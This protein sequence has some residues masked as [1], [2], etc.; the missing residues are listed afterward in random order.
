MAV[1]LE[2]HCHVEEVVGFGGHAKGPQREESIDRASRKRVHDRMKVLNIPPI[3]GREIDVLRDTGEFSDVPRYWHEE[4]RDLKDKLESGKVSQFVGHPPGPLEKSKTGPRKDGR[5]YT[6]EFRRYE[7]LRHI[8]KG[9]ND[10]LR[11][12]QDLVAQQAEI[13]ALDLR[14]HDP[15]LSDEEREA[16]L[17]EYDTRNEALKE[18]VSTLTYNKRNQFLFLTDDRHAFSMDPPLLSWDN[19]TYEPLT[20]SPSEFYNPRELALLDFQAKLPNTLPLTSEQ[21]IYMDLLGTALFARKGP[22]NLRVLKTVAPGAYE[23]LV[24]KVEEL[25]DASQGGRRE[26]DGVRVRAMTARML[27]RLAVEWGEWPFRPELRE[28]L[29]G[30]GKNQFDL[31]RRVGIFK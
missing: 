20:A 10:A 8:V 11:H 13:D 19:R 28:V 9:Q 1:L 2:A 22:Q 21:A 4:M 25:R 5:K 3:P 12:V 6:P 23:A 24:P 26:I 17:R 27:W 7:Y 15:G 18:K 30:F 14:S 16:L 29:R 31:T